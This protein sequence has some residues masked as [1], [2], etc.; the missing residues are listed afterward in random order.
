[1]LP[2]RSLGIIA[3]TGGDAMQ[4]G[5]VLPITPM[6]MEHRDVATP[7]R[8]APD[9]AIEVIQALDPTPHERAQYDRRV[10]VEGRA[11]HRRHR[12]NDMSID[13]PFVEPRAHLAD[14]GIHVDLGAP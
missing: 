6:G 2:T 8:L 9:G 11:E 4:V 7:K 13:H 14:P 5:M 3:A 10:L 12:Q 1:M